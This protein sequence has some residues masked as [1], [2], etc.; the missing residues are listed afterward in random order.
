MA[1]FPESFACEGVKTV[2]PELATA[3]NDRPEHG[4]LYNALVYIGKLIGVV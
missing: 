3:E 1:Q 4:F 2:K